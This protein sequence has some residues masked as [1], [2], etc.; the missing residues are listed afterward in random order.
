[1][2]EEKD[3]TYNGWPNYETWALAS[4][5]SNDLKE[6]EFIR[7]LVK[8]PLKT[9]EMEDALKELWDMK[10]E[11]VLPCSSVFT[12]L[13][14]SSISRVDWRRIIENAKTWE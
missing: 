13:L 9:C 11:E 6:Y 1:M 3:T 5:I 8:G 7:D 14:N 10:V 2:S 4:W 12:D